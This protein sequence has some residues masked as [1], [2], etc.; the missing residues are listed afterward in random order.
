MS[1][2]PFSKGDIENAYPVECKDPDRLVVVANETNNTLKLEKARQRVQWMD[3][4]TNSFANRCLPLLSAN[5]LGWVISCPETF[6]ATW[7]G[8]A[9]ENS[10]KIEHNGDN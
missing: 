3:D 2:C 4:T 8:S 10:I 9:G 6:T 5:E 7:D 1:E